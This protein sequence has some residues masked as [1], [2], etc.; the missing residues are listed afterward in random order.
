MILA[1]DGDSVVGDLLGQGQIFGAGD[2]VVDSIEIDEAVFVQ[3]EGGLGA[4]DLENGFVDAALGNLSALCRVQ[5]SVV[6]AV[7]IS[8]D[9]DVVGAS[10]HGLDGGT[11][12]TL[13]GVA[14]EDAGDAVHIHCVGD[15]DAPEAQAHPG[16][17]GC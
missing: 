2:Q 4:Q 15:D 13:R 1:H 9:E 10:L 16:A 12:G 7:E 14:A 6:C 5:N 11:A 17:G 3:P 8:G